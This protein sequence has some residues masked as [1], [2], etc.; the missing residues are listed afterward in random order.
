MAALLVGIAVMGV[1]MA[2]AMPVWRQMATR[3][4]EA[5][6][7]FRGEQYARGIALFQRKYPGAFPPS[8]DVLV[9]QKFVRRKYKD[10]MTKDGE[11]Q[12][13]YMAQAA[14]GRGPGGAPGRGAGRRHGG[15]RGRR[16]GSGTA[17][18]PGPAD[19]RQASARQA[20]PAARGRP[21]SASSASPRH[22][23]SG[24]QGPLALQRVAVPV[25]PGVGPARR[26]GRAP[27]PAA[28]GHG[29]AGTGP[30]HGLPGHADRAAC[31]PG[32]PGGQGQGPGGARRP[33]QGPGTVPARSS[34]AGRAAAPAA[35]RP[36]GLGIGL[37]TH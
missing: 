6:L 8:L 24:L 29:P 13:L 37:I 11:F 27:G 33:G 31:G 34:R 15:G 7:V 17:R 2:I 18:R 23:R 30:G 35:C 28:A 32:G 3:E 22:S 9:E 25:Q 16:G 19:Q 14:G 1:L 26:T 36:R 4:K 21:S 10:P 5:E 12:P 20:P